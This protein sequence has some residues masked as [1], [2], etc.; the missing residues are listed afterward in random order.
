M[1]RDWKMEKRIEKGQEEREI[2][3][4]RETEGRDSEEM[5]RERDSEIQR[6]RLRGK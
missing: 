2:E 3:R 1:K 4:Q 5:E 6:N